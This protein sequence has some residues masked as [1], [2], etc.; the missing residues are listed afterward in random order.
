MRELLA[1]K[2]L[3]VLGG[4]NKFLSMLKRSRAEKII[5]CFLPVQAN[6]CRKQEE[7]FQHKPIRN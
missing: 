5:L 1:Q 6:N 3:F 4:I 7:T 2:Q